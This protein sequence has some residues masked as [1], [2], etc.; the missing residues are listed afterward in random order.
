MF[1]DKEYD[2]KMDIIPEAEVLSD[3]KQLE[4]VLQVGEGVETHCSN[5][6]SKYSAISRWIK[7][8]NIGIGTGSHL[9]VDQFG[10]ALIP[11]DISQSSDTFIAYK[12]TANGNCLFNSVSRLLVGNDSIS[13]H[14]R[15]LTALELSMNTEFYAEHPRLHVSYDSGFCKATMFTI[16][17]STLGIGIWDISKNRTKAIQAEARVASKTK[18]WAGMVHL[19]ALASVIARPIFSVYPN[20]PLVFRKLLHGTIQPRVAEHIQAQEST[21]YIMWSRDGNFDATSGRWYEPNHFIPLLKSE[22]VNKETKE[23]KKTQGAKITDFFQG[24]GSKRKSSELPG[25]EFP[26]R[27]RQTDYTAKKNTRML[28]SETAERWKSNDLATYEANVWLTYDEEF[29]GGKKYCTSLKCKVC[30]EF[31][32]SINKRHNFSR[33]F[34]DGSTNFKVTSVID[35][36]NSEIHKI[37]LNLFRR[38]CGKPATPINKEKNQPTLNFKLDPQQQEE[39]K[40]KFDISYF[41]VKEEL[42]LTK[43]EKIIELEKRHGVSHGSSYSNRTAATNFISYQSDQLKSQL[44]KDIANAKFFSVIFD[45]TTDCAVVEQEAVFAIYFDPDPDL[46]DASA[47]DGQEPKVKVQMGFLSVENLTSS[48]AEGVVGGI[49]SALE[50]LGLSDVGMPP[51]SPIGL[52]GDGCNTNRGEKG[53]VIALLKKEFP[54]FVFVWC[55]AHRLE[56][57]LKDGLNGTYFKEVD[58]CLLRLYYLY[59]K[60]PKKMRGLEELYNS[61]KQCL[62]FV[63]GSLKPKRASGTRWILHKVCA[64][65]LLVD[66]F[67][68]YMQHIE[69]LS[70]DNSVKQKDQ[71]KLRGY[72]RK[73]KT[74]KMFVYSCFFIDLLQSS[75]SLSAAFQDLDVDAV[76]ASQAMS[77]AKKQLDSLMKNEVQNLR[78]V[79]YYL[80]KVEDATYQGVELSGFDDAVNSLQKDFSMYVKLVKGEIESR[81]EGSDDFTEV[82]TV[83]NCEL[84]NQNYKM[85]E[86]VETT[87]LKFCQ[88]FQEPLKQ[89]G[90]KVTEPELLEE[91]HDMVDY[92]V[93]FLKPATQHYRATWYKLFHSS[94][95]VNWQNILLVVRLLFSLPVSNAATERFFST[96]KRVKSSKRA[97]LSQPTLL[98]ILRITTEGPPLKKYDATNAVLAWHEDKVRRPNQKTQ[99][100]YKKRRSTKKVIPT[101]EFSSTSSSPTITD[102]DTENDDTSVSNTQ[103]TLQE[104]LSEQ[105]SECDTLFEDGDDL[106]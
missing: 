16:C 24:Q 80:G 47:N 64:L 95:I 50:S 3:L 91:W 82:A 68:I 27:K 39:M 37:A 90:F 67:G 106:E 15:L 7:K 28:R 56:L 60:S 26:E 6:K 99:R 32:T 101:S 73:W 53:G 9:E 23:S 75:A 52:G 105:D 41:V 57:A 38:K 87:I 30:S 36:A 85:D 31:E 83:L 4:N 96:L 78:I 54:W 84:W 48:T 70:C 63:E 13:C 103:E 12:S 92:T 25:L 76:S 18:E 33:T 46:D 102:S 88:Q 8:T 42:P 74:G 19:M 29:I 35:H 94:R 97:S 69:S 20:V 10:Q 89:Q 65:K 81:L 58:E 2:S 55:V 40:R 17:L 59:E 66:K 22:Q 93:Q 62:E 1:K 45:G 77:K 21:V 11:D 61:Y 100:S 14:L 5:L 51:P 104:L 72:L 98:S 71:A 44:S 79:K 86:N 49:K 43:Y 34:I